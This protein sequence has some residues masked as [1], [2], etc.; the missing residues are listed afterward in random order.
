MY[1]IE[2]W[3]RKLVEHVEDIELMFKR[4][5][6]GPRTLT[7]IIDSEVEVDVGGDRIYG[8]VDDVDGIWVKLKIRSEKEEYEYLIPIFNIRCIKTSRPFQDTPR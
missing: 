7:K 1:D 3:L 5:I 8:V 2:Y 4:L 6:E